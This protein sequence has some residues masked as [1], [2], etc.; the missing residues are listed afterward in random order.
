MILTDNGND[1]ELVDVDVPWFDLTECYDDLVMRWGSI[2]MSCIVSL[3]RETSSPAGTK[4]NSLYG[5][6]EGRPRIDRITNKPTEFWI[7]FDFSRAQDFFFNK[8]TSPHY[9]ENS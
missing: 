4:I 9:D 7:G 8:D 3:S 6:D 1:V 2:V 5:W